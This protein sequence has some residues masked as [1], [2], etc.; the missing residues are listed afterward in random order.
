[1]VCAVL[2]SAYLSNHGVTCATAITIRVMLRCFETYVENK[3]FTQYIISK[4]ANHYT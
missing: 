2:D 4:F 3:Y 1:M